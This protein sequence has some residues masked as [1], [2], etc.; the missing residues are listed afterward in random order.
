MHLRRQAIL[1]FQIKRFSAQ[2]DGEEYR[3]D[4]KDEEDWQ[5]IRGEQDRGFGDESEVLQNGFASFVPP[6]E[7]HQTPL[8]DLLASMMAGAEVRGQRVEQVAIHTAGLPGDSLPV[9]SHI[10]DFFSRYI[11]HAREYLVSLC[12]VEMAD[13]IEWK[14]RGRAVMEVV[15]KLCW[16][17]KSMDSLTGN[18]E[19]K[20]Y[21]DV[22][23]FGER[24]VEG[25]DDVYGADGEMITF[26]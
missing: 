17:Q 13:Y 4:P 24:A 22:V 15:Q 21:Y 5:G 16:L 19:A 3:P 8:R 7:N 10:Y 23:Y 2:A 14:H 9:D 18:D 25:L 6:P 1:K 12:N 20:V 26:V 11:K